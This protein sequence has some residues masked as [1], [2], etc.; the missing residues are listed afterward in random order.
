MLRNRPPKAGNRG[1][2]PRNTT[3]VLVLVFGLLSIG[4]YAFHEDGLPHDIQKP[5]EGPG[6]AD[7]GRSPLRFSSNGIQL[8]SWLPLSNFGDPIS[9]ANT[10]EGYVSPSGTEYALLGLSHGVG[11]VRLSDPGSP[12]VL[13]VDGSNRFI[14]GPTS[15]WRDIRVYG[16]Y[17]YAVSEGGGG[18]QVMDLSQI[19]SNVVT[20]VNTVTAGGGTTATHTVYINAESGY[21]YRCGGGGSPYQGLRIYSLADPANPVHEG[22]WNNRYV[23]EA[24]VVSYTSGPYAGMEVAFCF[25]ENTSSGGAA[26]IDILNVTDKS[27][28]QQLSFVTYPNATFSHQGWLSEDRKY[29]YHND[30][31]DES[32][33]GIASR[34]RIFDVQDL[35]NPSYVGFFSSGAASID[36]NLYVRGNRIFESNYRSGLRVFDAT[37]PLNAVEIGYFDTYPDDDNPSFNSLWD[38]DPYLPSGIVLG[39]DIEKGL[40]VWWIG[41][42]ELTFAYPDGLPPMLDPGGDTLRVQVVEADSGV[43]DPDTVALHYDLGNGFNVLPLTDTGGYIF[44]AAFPPAACGTVVAF[45]FSAKSTNGITWRDPSTAPDGRYIAYYSLAVNVELADDMESDSGWVVGAAGDTAISGI[46]V[47]VDPNGTVA[48]PE[49]DHTPGGTHCWVTGQGSPGGGAGDADVD[50]GRTTLTTPVYDVTGMTLP[51][52]GYWRWY[53]NSAGGSPGADVFRVDISNNGGASWINV[54]T[55]GPTG[56]G[57]SGGWFYHEFAVADFVVPT[58]QVRLRFIAEDAGAGSLIEAAVDDLQILSFDCPADCN[59]NGTDDVEDIASGFSLDCNLNGQPDE[60]DGFVPPPYGDIAP[61]GGD[62]RVELADILCILS[63]YASFDDCPPGDIWPCPEPDQIIEVS[64]VLAGLAA[65]AGNP[66]CPAP[67]PVR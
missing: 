22:T 20:L 10:V 44:E 17:A 64:D 47:R 3:P 39:S 32:S 51:H 34:T 63:G 35:L 5:W 65:Y 58:P 28:I 24:Q 29:L 12:E 38:N 52:V 50:G 18:I 57:T 43:L 14:T 37:D 56:P 9:S 13:A 66:S 31:L 40:F 6:V 4:L 21:L 1:L 7:G 41:E 61:P 45:Y 11:F 67:C 54:E 8:L 60:C 25:S 62:G 15:L 48:Q 59:G 42:P 27:N 46:W 36:H 2:Q 53:S 26:G 30:E 55:V 16:H 33:A 19:D 23:H 49:D